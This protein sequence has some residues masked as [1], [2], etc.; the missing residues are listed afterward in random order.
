MYII[1]YVNYVSLSEWSTLLTGF[2]RFWRLRGER[3]VKPIDAQ[4]HDAHVWCIGFSRA[5]YA[6][7]DVSGVASFITTDEQLQ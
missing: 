5:G 7:G 4:L 6:L 1:F 2:L 3:Q